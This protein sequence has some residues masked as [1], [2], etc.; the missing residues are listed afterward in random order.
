M[1]WY[2]PK[3]FRK[4]INKMLNL[5]CELCNKPFMTSHT[6]VTFC[7]DCEDEVMNLVEE[8]NEE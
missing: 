4:Q 6:L 7:N 3:V 8:W 2:N 1:S 5:C